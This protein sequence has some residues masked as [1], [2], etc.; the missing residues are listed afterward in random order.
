MAALFALHPAHVESVAWV[1]ERKDVLSTLF[2]LLTLAAYAGW[3]RSGRSGLYR[4]SLALFALG[5]MAKPMLVTLPLT[6]LLF[7][8]WP[9][10]RFPAWDGLRPSAGAWRAMGR[11]LLEKAPFFALTLASAAVT[12]LA[13]RGAMVDPGGADPARSGSPTA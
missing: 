1:A 6:L 5:L 13:Q 11:L 3:A 7:D 4:L 2:W 9:L 10:G 8:L 12:L